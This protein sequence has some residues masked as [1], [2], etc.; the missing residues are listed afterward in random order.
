MG[1]KLDAIIKKVMLEGPLTINTTTR[2]DIVDISGVENSLSIQLD[3]EN[4]VGLNA[5][6]SV[7]VSVNSRDF[8]EIPESI[9]NI[10]D[11]N[12]THIW[13]FSEQGTNYIRVV[14]TINSG[15][16]DIEEIILSGKRRH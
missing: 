8:V 7:E 14:I 16:L 6:I 1:N 13:N 5:D 3:Y 9:Q 12:G 2:S 4:G 11:V 15:S 10:T